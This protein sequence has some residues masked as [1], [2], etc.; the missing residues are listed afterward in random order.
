M[1][2]KDDTNATELNDLEELIPDIA[3]KVG[4]KMPLL[5]LKPTY[6]VN[7][8]ITKFLSILICIFQVEDAEYMKKTTEDI[9]KT[10]ANIAKESLGEV[11]N[12]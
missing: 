8:L 4:T 5:N 11:L 7:G 10:A 2:E 3:A 9:I 12:S 6:L 1:K